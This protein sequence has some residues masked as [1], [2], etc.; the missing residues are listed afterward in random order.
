MQ[1][2]LAELAA[3]VHGQLIG[4]GD[5]LIRGAAPLGDAGPG[6][7]TLIDRAERDKSLRSSR[8][9]AVVAPRSVEP[10]GVPV[11]QVD[12][13][14]QAFAVIVAR[15]RPARSAD[16]IGISPQAVVSPTAKVGQDVDV[17]PLATIG[18]DVTIA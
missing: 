2:T 17:H 1:A 16:R 12:D 3:L 13:V 15:F 18:D 5:L 4:D 6:E 8:A 11:I 14:H 9:S 7:I 10:N